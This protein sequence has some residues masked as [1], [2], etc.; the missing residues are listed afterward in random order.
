MAE[1][2]LWAG[3]SGTK[4]KYYVHSLNP[5]FK[6][7]GGNYIFAKRSS[8]PGQWL[9]VYIGQTKN[10]DQRH[11]DHNEEACAKRNGATHIHAHLNATQ[12]ARLAEEADL[13]ANSN[14]PCNG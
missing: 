13:L 4:Y 6:A 10:L 8:T 3:A 9:A 7:E 1:E 11:E 2:M 5:S 14:P 12:A